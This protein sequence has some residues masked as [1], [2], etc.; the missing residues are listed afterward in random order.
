VKTLFYRQFLYCLVAAILL[1]HSA[2]ANEGI[3]LDGRVSPGFEAVE[4]F[5][6]ANRTDYEG[7]VRIELHVKSA[8]S[9][10]Q[11]H[12]E[13]MNF[14]RVALEGKGGQ[15]DV[16][17]EVGEE[18]LVTA[19]V[20]RELE[21][22]NYTLEIDF[23]KDYNTQAVGLYRMEHE[24]QGYLFTQFQAVDARKAF[25]CWDEPVFKIPFK[26]TVHLPDGQ[27]AVSNTPI[28]KFG[29]EN[30]MQTIVFQKTRPLP[31][32]LVALIAGPFESVPME[33]LSVPGRIYTVKGQ[34][35]LTGLATEYSP[36]ILEALE[37]YFGS[38]YPYKKL[39]YVA[40]P[41]YWPGAMENAGLITFRDGILLVD[42]AGASVG[43]KSF[44]ARVIVHEIS[45]M[46]FGDMVTMEWWDDLWLNEAFASWLG[47]KM[48][49][50]LFPQ[51]GTDIQ[52]LQTV[53]GV[54]NL[55]ARPSTKPVHRKVTK[56]SEM[57]ED[58][59]I[60]YEKGQTILNMVEDWIG[61]DEFRNGVVDYIDSNRWGSTVAADLWMALSQASGKNLEPV[62]SSF[63]DQPGCPIVTVG[64]AGRGMLEIK[65]ERFLNAGVDAPEQLWTI[66]V[67]VKYFDGKEIQTRTFLL[68][69]RS[70]RVELGTDVEWALPN[71]GAI[72]YYRWSAPLH[73]V[74]Q[75]AADPMGTLD[76]RE[77]AVFLANV[78]A[79][80]NAGEIN[81]ADYLAILSSLGKTPEP[82][83]VSAVMN[84]LGSTEMAFVTDDLCDPFAGY[85]RA[86]LGPALDRF[87]LEKTDGEEESISTL[88]PRLL[89]WLGLQGQRQD[90]RQHCKKLA[91]IYLADP[92]AVD[93]SV[94]GV[95]LM[96][97]AREGTR[98]DFE[99]FKQRFETAEVPA[100]RNRFLSAMGSFSDED[101]QDEVLV[102]LLNGPV[103]PN[104][105]FR[106]IGGISS[107]TAGRDK[108]YRWMADNYETLTAKFP[109]VVASYMPYFAGGCSAERLAAAQRFFAEPEHDVQGTDNNMVK[110]A[111]QVMD[112]VNL[113]EREGA[114]VADYLSR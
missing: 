30:D 46:W 54:M 28:N 42:P 29:L 5:L 2:I 60:T 91:G 78:R 63:L 95:A 97:A 64:V 17:L 48:T 57:F 68:E 72:G 34:K 106:A 9:T 82:E 101:L 86:T 105:I 3:R 27:T 99:T 7:S 98:A 70:K 62:L 83:I 108:C 93:P 35:H 44:L 59:G 8:T 92:N 113:R 71:A 6:D 49:H 79:L 14:D 55:D 15:Y 111:D 61:P 76:R 65:Q 69:E 18:G 12:A 53:Q 43:Q 25:P 77:R 1:P 80:L 112:C 103:R 67:H 20:D 100:E 10:F 109:P 90:V 36:V 102:Y 13:E 4:L 73:M 39:D 24:G 22:G 94:A 74:I 47:N 110:V 81:G 26:L 66:P 41:E 16:N 107:T 31:T 104:D 11:F 40:V 58:I 75:M 45:H 89:A 87:G 38:A 51:F 84:E 37:G 19:T 33:G 23:S 21:K 50:K 56:T 96:V 88:R 85:I 52:R 32:Y 114:V